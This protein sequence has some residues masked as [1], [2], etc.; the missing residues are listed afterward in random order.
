MFMERTLGELKPIIDQLH[1]L[2]PYEGA[3]ESPRSKNKA[4][5]KYRR[6]TNCVYDF[7]NNGLIN[8]RSEFV[9]MF[10]NAPYIDSFRYMS[11]DGWDRW[12]DIIAPQFRQIIMD[13]A[14]EQGI[15]SEPTYLDLYSDEVA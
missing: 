9:R 5:D 6:A 11:P 12:E 8:R 7:F 1:K 3:C 14:K 15:Q 2:V 13:A 4:L 10:G